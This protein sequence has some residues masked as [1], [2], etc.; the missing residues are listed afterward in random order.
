VSLEKRIL[1]G[2]ERNKK[3]QT[4]FSDDSLFEKMAENLKK[5]QEQIFKKTS[6]KQMRL[7]TKNKNISSLKEFI[8]SNKLCS[9]FFLL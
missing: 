2:K 8:C 5:I 9:L 7:L 4:S 1:D 3:R 6:I